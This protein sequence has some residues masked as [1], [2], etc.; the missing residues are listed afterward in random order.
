MLGNPSETRD[1]MLQTIALA[2]KLDPDYIHA[3]LTTPFPATELYRQGLAQGVLK[4]DYWKEFAE[5][6][7]KGFE[8]YFW[9][10]S[11]TKDELVAMLKHAYRTFYMRPSYMF[12]QMLKTK[13][14]KDLLRKTRSGLKLLGA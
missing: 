4:R 5:D 9:E 10:E 14:F 3:G 7:Q 13:G 11:L 12:R 1:E 8:P 2:K 6:P